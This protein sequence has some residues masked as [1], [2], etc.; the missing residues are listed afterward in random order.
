MT[1]TRDQIELAVRAFI[2]REGRQPTCVDLHNGGNLRHG[3]PAEQT[4]RREYGSWNQMLRDLDLPIL[5]LSPGEAW[6]TVERM[7]SRGATA[8]EIADAVGTTRESVYQMFFSRGLRISDFPRG[9]VT[10]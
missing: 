7:A 4:V 6:P 2:A 3:M 5:R 9:R 10:S 8:G 1:W